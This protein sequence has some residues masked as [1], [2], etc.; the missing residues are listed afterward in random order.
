MAQGSVL[1]F[2][3]VDFDLDDAEDEDVELAAHPATPI[4]SNMATARRVVVVFGFVVV[5]IA[6]NPFD[7]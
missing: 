2:S 5:V 1:L 6:V 7:A 4:I 3:R